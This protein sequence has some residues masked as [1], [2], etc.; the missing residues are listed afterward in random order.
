MTTISLAQPAIIQPSRL[1]LLLRY[2]RRN[3]SLAVGLFILLM[4]VMFTV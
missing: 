4:L 2:L 1:T 3:K